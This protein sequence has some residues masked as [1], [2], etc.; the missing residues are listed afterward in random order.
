[1]HAGGQSTWQL[2]RCRTAVVNHKHLWEQR[3]LIMLGGPRISGMG[4]MDKEQDHLLKTCGDFFCS[5]TEYQMK[6]N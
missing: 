3:E 1:M 2:R 6:F 5:T 4:K